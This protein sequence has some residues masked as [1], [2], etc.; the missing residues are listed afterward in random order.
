MRLVRFAHKSPS[1]CTDWHKCVYDENNHFGDTCLTAQALNKMQLPDNVL[2]W[3]RPS[4]DLPF[5][6]SPIAPAGD[7]S[8][9]SPVAAPFHTLDGTHPRIYSSIAQWPLEV[10][11]M[12][13]A[14]NRLFIFLRP[15]MHCCTARPGQDDD[16]SRIVFQLPFRIKKP[17]RVRRSRSAHRN[18]KK[19]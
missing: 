13:I 7:D 19:R 6:Q 12:L 1:V 8:N 9:A 18:R 11:I 5:S 10:S 2:M 4:D 16:D 17:T 15:Q 14:W 3:A